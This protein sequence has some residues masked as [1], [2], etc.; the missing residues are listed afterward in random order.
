MSGHVEFGNTIVFSSFIGSVMS[1]KYRFLRK[2][3]KK[4]VRKPSERKKYASTH[5]FSFFLS[6]FFLFFKSEHIAVAAIADCLKI[7]TAREET[8]QNRHV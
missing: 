7:T 4:S 2:K 1:Q 3:I 8:A 5:L 6:S